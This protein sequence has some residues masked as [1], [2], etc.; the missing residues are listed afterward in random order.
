MKY[1]KV[2]DPEGNYGMVYKE[3][4]NE[5]ILPFNP[6]ENCESGGLYFASKDIFA[7]YDYGY[8]IYEVEP[9]G[10]IYENTKECINP[11][12]SQKFK[13]H[14][15]NMKLL[16]DKWDLDVIKYLIKNGANIH[17]CGDCVLSR[18]A[19]YGRL[20]VV[21]YLV[22]KGANIHAMDDDALSRAAQYGR[23]KV[24]N[25]LKSKIIEIL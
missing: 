13:A 11:N 12:M 3:G 1:F 2:V 23:L 22:K 8:L 25:F 24:V 6:S 7:F 10:E 21:K 15:L 9:V 18:A 16:G 14:A 20:K 17:A 4:Y 5:D 19:Q